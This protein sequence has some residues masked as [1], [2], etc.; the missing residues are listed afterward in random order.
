MGDSLTASAGL[1]ATNLLEMFVENRGA[2]A[3]IG[4]QR[5][6]R[7]HLTLPN[8]LKVRLFLA[9]S[10]HEFNPKLIGYA[11][12]DFSTTQSPSQL[13]VAE[14]CA[15]SGDMPFMVKYYSRYNVSDI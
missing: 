2:S 4:G 10:S 7:A 3:F 9:D 1:Y 14:I 15:M 8:I 12:G 6:L 13:D 5:T 11:Y